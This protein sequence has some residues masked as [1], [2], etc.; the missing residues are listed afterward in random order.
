MSILDF[1]FYKDPIAHWP[2]HVRTD[3]FFDM[4]KFTVNGAKL[5]EH[6]EALQV[7]GHPD[8]PKAVKVQQFCY[9]AS[10]FVVEMSE[11]KTDFVAFVF[12]DDFQEGFQECALTLRLPGPKPA[13]LSSNTTRQELEQLLGP[14]QHEDTDAEET[15]LSYKRHGVELEL[16]LTLEGRLKRVNIFRPD[17]NA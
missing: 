2:K 5:G 16:E 12:Q 7:F 9:F 10:G 17:I 6:Y 8:N 13:N 14:P 4:G 15:I 3:I 1:F 11:N